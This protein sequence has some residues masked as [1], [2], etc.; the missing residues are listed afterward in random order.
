MRELVMRAWL[1]IQA[2]VAAAIGTWKVT[3][4]KVGSRF[5]SLADSC[6]DCGHAPHVGICN[7]PDGIGGC[8]CTS[9][10]IR[11]ADEVREDIDRLDRALRDLDRDLAS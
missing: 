9:S 6:S 11:T 5:S 3:G 8:Y 1:A 4:I 10:R 2:G 7:V